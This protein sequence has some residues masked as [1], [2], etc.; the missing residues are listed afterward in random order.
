MCCSC[1]GGDDGGGDDGGGDDCSDTNGS[2][3]DSYGDDCDW[4]DSNEW[5]CG[6]YGDSDFRLSNVLWVRQWRRWGAA[7]AV[8]SAPMPAVTSAPIARRPCA[9]DGR[10]PVL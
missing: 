9:N 10:G 5:A 8:T 2:A 3:I 7:S 1:G 6:D 4:Y